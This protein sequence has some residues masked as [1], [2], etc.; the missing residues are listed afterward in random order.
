MHRQLIAVV[1]LAIGVSACQGGGATAPTV[2]TGTPAP[3]PTA[4]PTPVPVSKSVVT[5]W[6]G[7]AHP[8][9]A[10]YAHDDRRSPRDASP[11]TPYP[12]LL[13]PCDPNVET[14]VSADTQVAADAQEVVSPAPTDS[15]S[16]APTPS[17]TIVSGPLHLGPASATSN[18]SYP[19]AQVLI[20]APTGTPAGVYR[21]AATFPDGTTQTIAVQ[22]YQ[23]VTI[24]VGLS[25]FSNAPQQIG[26]SFATGTA[27][28]NTAVADVWLDA[29]GVLHCAQGCR[30]FVNGVAPATEPS[31][32][33]GT[34]VDYAGI[35]PASWGADFSTIAVTQL[36][37]VVGTTLLLVKGAD[38]AI[39]K[40]LVTYLSVGTGGS[41]F[42]G[43]G[44]GSGGGA[45][46]AY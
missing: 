20:G 26:W 28:N 6:R 19:G 17:W 21:A 35:S 32:V 44:L 16:P 18:G 15:P 3:T 38:G 10:S 39:D 4:T 45:S 13:G 42:S 27:T 41:T 43:L 33:S 1:M 29:S 2:G 8:S 24:G 36:Q 5:E 31:F 40:L 9:G 46:F 12:I 22:V 11:S 37:Q 14:C 25:P 34:Q 7:A 30:A 23:H